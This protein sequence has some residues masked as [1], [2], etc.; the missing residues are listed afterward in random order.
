MCFGLAW[1][2][3]FL[4]WLVVV[5]GLVAIFRIFLPMIFGWLGWAG[6]VAMRIINILI[7]MIVIVALI[8]FIFDVAGCLLGSGFPHRLG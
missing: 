1:I 3:N 6:D 2:E 7:A 8:V 5:C 4:I